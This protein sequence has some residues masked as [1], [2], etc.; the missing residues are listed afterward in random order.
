KFSGRGR[1][2]YVI[3]VN[4]MLRA[5]RFSTKNYALKS[6]T[7]DR[8]YETRLAAA[9]L[10][11]GMNKTYFLTSLAENDINLNRETLSNLA[12]YEPRTFQ[13]LVQ[14]VK[15]RSEEVGLQS[16]VLGSVHGTESRGILDEVKKH[17]WSTKSRTDEVD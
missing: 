13:S 6:E 5:M 12:I 2:C 9:C 4:R 11:H 10:E 7:L 16:R 17:R 15:E 8:L 1:N 3:G 14:F